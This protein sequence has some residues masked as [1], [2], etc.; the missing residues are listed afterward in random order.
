MDE[1]VEIQKN[2]EDIEPEEGNLEYLEAKLKK[3][4]PTQTRF[5]NQIKMAK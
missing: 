2:D 1:D 5:T 3:V 4:N